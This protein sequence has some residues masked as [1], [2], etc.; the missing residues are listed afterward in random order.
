M[1]RQ[2]DPDATGDVD[3]LL[4]SVGLGHGRRRTLA[5]SWQ[6]GGRRTKPKRSSPQPLAK[7]SSARAS[8]TTAV[9]GNAVQ[10][11]APENNLAVVRVPGW[12]RYDWLR[13]GFSTRAG[14]VSSIYGPDTGEGTLNLGWTEHD[15]AVNVAENRRRFLAEVAGV[16]TRAALSPRSRHSVPCSLFPAS[17]LVTLRQV[18]SGMLRVVESEAGTLREQSFA[19][20]LQTPAG[21]AVL[22]GDA[23]MTDV[24]G[25]FLGIQTADCV[26]V[27]IADVRKRAVAAFHAGWRGTLARIVE[28]GIGTMRLR[29]GSR[30]QDL[31]AVVG[32][33]IGPCCYAVG[34]EMRTEFESQFAYAPQ[35]FTEVFDSDP[36]R[37]KYPLLFLT[38]RAPGHSDIG[39]QVH[40]DLW[41]ANRRQLLDAGIPASRITVVGECTACAGLGTAAGRKFFSHRAEC[42]FTGRMLSVVGIARAVR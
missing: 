10:R 32:P 17:C 1:N 39:P 34:E 19:G 28:R 23:M 8:A 24:P 16:D 36:V 35:L 9:S 6:N 13:H 21:R 20:H 18:H 22:R 12:Q 33:S 3:D 31:V 14:G 2:A 4:A 42:G 7:H 27:L 41:Q 15:E 26:P 11:T 37:D 29:Y 30:P 5:G 25:V 40:L 38:A